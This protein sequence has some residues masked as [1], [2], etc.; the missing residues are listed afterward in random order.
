MAVTTESI[1]LGDLT[2]DV[3]V[4]GTSGEGVILLHGF[5]ETSHMWL[6]L[7]E[8]LA[9]AGYH[10]VAADQ[11]GYSEGARPEGKHHYT[12][13]ALAKD[14]LALADHFGWEHFH[15]IGHDH[16]AGLG[17]LVTGRHPERVASWTAMSVPHIDAFG[18]AIA[19]NPEQSEKSQYILFFQQEGAAEEAMSANDFAG[20]QAIWNQSSAAE[21]EEYL[22]VF[23]QPGA[24]TG[25]LNWYR[26]ALSTDHPR[27][28]VGV[29]STPTLFIWGNQDMAIGRPGVDATPP[30]MA[31]PYRFVELDVGHWLIQEAETEVCEAVVE[32]LKNY[33][34]S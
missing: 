6:P 11:R 8:V 19:S 32:Q 27:E 21:R 13:D 20:L 9:G 7:M 2:F 16:G 12:Y 5:P 31:G 18:N 3:R 10:A 4:A 15:L 24:L 34:I 30:L 1:T 17:W 28:P 25:A 26:G 22:R 29:I 23:R 14:V 33:P